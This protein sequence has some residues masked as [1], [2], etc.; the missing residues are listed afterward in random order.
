MKIR[1][2]K[3][4]FVVSRCS[5]IFKNKLDNLSKISWNGEKKEGNKDI[6]E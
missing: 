2:D 1:R 5:S 4:D 6:L 3:I